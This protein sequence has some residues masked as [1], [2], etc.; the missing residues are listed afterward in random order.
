MDKRYMRVQY[1]QY[2]HTDKRKKEKVGSKEFSAVVSK[3]KNI[4][5]HFFGLIQYEIP[6]ETNEYWKRTTEATVF[7]SAIH[8]SKKY[9]S[10]LYIIVAVYAKAN[11]IVYVIV[12]QRHGV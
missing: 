6:D 5:Q 7:H 1:N 9:R 8:N 3:Q 10:V 4:T 11:G 2:W 12:R